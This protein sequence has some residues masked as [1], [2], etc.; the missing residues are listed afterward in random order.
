M[1]SQLIAG[2][3]VRHIG[4]VVGV[5]RLLVGTSECSSGSSFGPLAM[6]VVSMSAGAVSGCRQYE[7]DVLLVIDVRLVRRDVGDKV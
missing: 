1:T 2:V 6:S 3:A 4:D 5:V 7:T